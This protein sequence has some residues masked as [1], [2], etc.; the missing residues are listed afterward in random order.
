MTNTCR[1]STH[2][3]KLSSSG[4]IY[5]GTGPGSGR[6][7]CSSEKGLRGL[8]YRFPSGL[9]MNRHYL[10]IDLP[11]GSAIYDMRK[12]WPSHSTSIEK[13]LSVIARLRIASMSFCRET[14]ESDAIRSIFLRKSSSKR[15]VKLAF[16]F[17]CFLST[18][19]TFIHH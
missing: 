8:R 1:A 12:I 9:V 10:A 13:S 16:S 6:G 2:I 7:K 15:M 14:F 4:P 19:T 3:D 18:L 17:F 11:M 5:L